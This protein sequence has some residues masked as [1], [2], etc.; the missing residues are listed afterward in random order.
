MYS[1][2]PWAINNGHVWPLAAPENLLQ[3]PRV[4]PLRCD[5]VT[6]LTV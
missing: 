4:S 2:I 1:N 5:R 3:I 6:K